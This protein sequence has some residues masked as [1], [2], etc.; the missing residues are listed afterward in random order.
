MLDLFFIFLVSVNL[1]LNKRFYILISDLVIVETAHSKN[2]IQVR[3]RESIFNFK[4]NIWYSLNFD[5]SIKQC[6]NCYFNCSKS[7]NSTR[8]IWSIENAWHFVFHKKGEKENMAD[9]SLGMNWNKEIICYF[10]ALLAQHAQRVCFFFFLVENGMWVT[11][12]GSRNFLCMLRWAYKSI[13]FLF[14]IVHVFFF[15]SFLFL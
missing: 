1:L 7:K 13:E 12:N 5:F 14:V 6:R 3:T 9:L 10:Y 15:H 2:R 8:L 4:M 11:R